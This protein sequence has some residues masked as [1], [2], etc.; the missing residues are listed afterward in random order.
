M[1]VTLVNVLV[2]PVHI[3]DFIAATRLNHEAS[4]QE[5]GNRRFDVLQSSENPGHF[6]LYEAYASAEAAVAHKQTAHYL[7]WRDTVAAWMAEPRQGVRYE[8]LFP[9]G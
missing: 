8:G 2:K 9:Q 1:H 3:E 4:I 6:I 5:P 7:V